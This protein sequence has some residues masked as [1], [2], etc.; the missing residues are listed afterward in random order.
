MKT[1]TTTT[2]TT[3]TIIIIMKESIP[4]MRLVLTKRELTTMPSASTREYGVRMQTQQ[5]Q[6][7]EAEKK[8]KSG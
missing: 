5:Y 4:F 7:Q 1:A 2:T 3:T 6:D 8:I